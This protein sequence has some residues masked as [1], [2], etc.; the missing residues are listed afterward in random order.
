MYV[1][2]GGGVATLAV[3]GGIRMVGGGP[4]ERMLP[5]PGAFVGETSCEALP[6]GA[7]PTSEEERTRPRTAKPRIPT[8]R[9]I[10]P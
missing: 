6:A 5:G 9:A 7:A 3:G 8:K 2:L 4:A 1:R 10:A